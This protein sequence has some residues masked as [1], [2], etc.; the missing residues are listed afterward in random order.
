MYAVGLVS[1]FMKNPKKDHF[2]A[3][4][5]ILRYIK[6]TLNHGLFYTYS[7]NSKLVGYSDS[8]DGGDLDDG[9]STSGY[10][11]HIGSAIFS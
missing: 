11:F 7:K 5:R 6:G 2:M 4:K 1:R 8:D 10:V 3:A 9:K